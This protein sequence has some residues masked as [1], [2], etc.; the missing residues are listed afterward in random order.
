MPKRYDW[1][2]IADGMGIEK[3]AA[4]PG[5]GKFDW[6]AI[7]DTMGVPRE[8]PQP[9]SLQGPVPLSEVPQPYGPQAPTV[10]GPPTQPPGSAD[11]TGAWESFM[12]GEGLAPGAPPG[13][14][15][16]KYQQEG[17]IIPGVLGAGENL[18]K[19]LNIPLGIASAGANLAAGA[20]RLLV[21]P[22]AELAGN[23]EHAAE[24]HQ[25]GM[26]QLETP[27]AM[28]PDIAIETVKTAAQAA[29]PV[30]GPAVSGL[31]PKYGPQIWASAR[32]HGWDFQEFQERMHEDPLG[33]ALFLMPVLHGVLQIPKAVGGKAPLEPSKAAPRDMASVRWSEL[34][35]KAKSLE[36]KAVRISEDFLRANDLPTDLGYGLA[37]G[38]GRPLGKDVP[39][40]R[41]THRGRALD[42]P[43][44]AL[45]ETTFGA[46]TLD[47][48]TRK[49]P[50]KPKQESTGRR[51]VD[52]AL[53]ELDRVY[54]E[55]RA[56]FGAE[57]K[58]M[59][60]SLDHLMQ[61]EVDLGAKLERA[62]EKLEAAQTSR[63]RVAAK[64]NR[65]KLSEQGFK[66]EEMEALSDSQIYVLA[67]ME[68]GKHRDAFLQ[69]LRDQYKIGLEDPLAGKVA[70]KPPVETPKPQDAEPPA[71]EV[72]PPAERPTGDFAP[73][74]PQEGQARVLRRQLQ[75]IERQTQKVL[76]DARVPPP[77]RAEKLAA[78]NKKRAK[79][80]AALERADP[81]VPPPSAA[82]PKP[83]VAEPRRTVYRGEGA[84]P[85]QVYGPEAVA[86]GRAVPLF[87][88]GVYYARTRKEAGQYG[89]VSA[90]PE[91][92]LR[93]PM[94]LDSD[95]KWFKLLRDADAPHLNN[96]AEAFYKN[97][98]GVAPDTLK[99]QKYLKGRGHDGLV[100]R[101]SEGDATK[102][103][104]DMAGHDQVVVFGEAPPA[105]P[106]PIEVKPKQP[107]RGT[108][109]P[110]PGEVSPEVIRNY[111][112]QNGGINWEGGPEALGITGGKSRKG[113]GLYSKDPKK[114]L[115]HWAEDLGQ[116]GG[117]FPSIE[118]AREWLVE[119]LADTT[120]GKPGD[121][122]AADRA[123]QKAHTERGVVRGQAQAERMGVGNPEAAIREAQGRGRNVKTLKTDELTPGDVIYIPS[124]NDVFRVKRNPDPGFTREGPEGDFVLQDG[125]K[126]KPLIGDVVD[127]VNLGR[128]NVRPAIPKPA[129]KPTE[130]ALPGMEEAP[131]QIADANRKVAAERKGRE[132]AARTGQGTL[133]DEEANARAKEAGR[134][135]RQE[136]AGKKEFEEKQTTFESPEG[137]GTTVG[138]PAE[139]T[140]TYE[141]AEAPKATPLEA[142][143]GGAQPAPERGKTPDQVI[144]QTQIVA[145]FRR[146]ALAPI[147]PGV[148]KRALG[149]FDWMRR[150][151]RLKDPAD[152]GVA[153][154]E[155]GHA[156]RAVLFDELP[157]TVPFRVKG[158][159]AAN[160]ELADLGKALYKSKKPAGGY[161]NE[162]LAEFTR[163]WATDRTAAKA[164]APEFAKVFEKRLKGSDPGMDLAETFDTVHRLKDLY[165]AQ[166]AVAKVLS[167]IVTA[168]GYY[169]PI[170]LNRLYAGLLD[171]DHYLYVAT[172]AANGGVFPGHGIGVP[173]TEGVSYRGWQGMAELQIEPGGGIPDL[174]PNNFLG[175]LRRHR[176][177][178]DEALASSA[179][180]HPAL[181]RGMR[182]QERVVAA[183]I[184]RFVKE[185]YVE[186]R[187]GY[188]YVTK[189]GRSVLT[190]PG[191]TK[192]YD[193]LHDI[194]KDLAD[195]PLETARGVATAS[196]SVR[197]QLRQRLPKK[198]FDL[199]RTRN[200]DRYTVFH[201]SLR[202]I[203]AAE[204]GH[205]PEVVAAAKRGDAKA[206]AYIEK[207]PG[208]DP[209]IKYSEALA[210]V[211]ELDSPRFRRGVER[212]VEFRNHQLDMTVHAGMRT[213]E[214]A[215]AIKEAWP[216]Y[217]PFHR[218]Y[219]DWGGAPAAKGRA[220]GFPTKDPIQRMKGSPLPIMDPI[221]ALVS[222]T[223]VITQAVKANGVKRALVEYM[224][225]HPGSG[226]AVEPTKLKSKAINVKIREAVQG[227]QDWLEQEAGLSR[228]EIEQM[229]LEGNFRIFRPQDHVPKGSNI[230]TYFD[231]G[232][233][234]YVELDPELYR[235]VEGMDHE[236]AAAMIRLLGA[237]ARWVRAGAT[238]TPDF[239]ARNIMRDFISAVTQSELGGANP[240]SGYRVKWTAKGARSRYLRDDHWFR[241]KASGASNA[242][243]IGMDKQYLK[244]SL[245]DMQRSMTKTGKAGNVVLHPIE[246]MQRLSEFMEETTRVG[247]FRRVTEELGM[248]QDSILKAM[249][250]SRDASIDFG[251]RG[252]W[253]EAPSM[254]VDFLNA[255]LQGVDKFGR[256]HVKAAK[257]VGASVKG[258]REGKVVMPTD[259]VRLATRLGTY[260]IL[261]SI[262]SYLSWHATDRYDEYDD[263]PAWK[264]DL[265][266]NFPLPGR[267]NY[268]SLPKAFEIGVLYGSGTERML[269]WIYRGDRERFREYAP[270]LFQSF[271]PNIFPAILRPMTEIAADWGLY[272]ER[273]I[274][275]RAERDIDPAYQY[276]P[277]TS[278]TAK[279][280]AGVIRSVPGAGRLMS[281]SRYKSSEISPRMVDHYIWS[282]TAGLGAYYAVPALDRVIGLLKH[283]ETGR[284]LGIG[285][286]SSRVQSFRDIPLVRS[287]VSKPEQIGQ[288]AI[289][290]YFDQLDDATRAHNTY[291]HLVKKN[292]DLAGEYLE[293]G[294]KWKNITAYE[295]LA[296]A[297]RGVSVLLKARADAG[298]E[299]NRELQRKLQEEVL[300]VVKQAMT[301]AEAALEDPTQAEAVR[302][303]ADLHAL[304]VGRDRDRAMLATTIEQMIEQGRNSD[305][306]A[307]TRTMTDEDRKWARAYA[308]R[309]RKRLKQSAVERKIDKSPKTLLRKLA[310]P[311]GR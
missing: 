82:G 240:F 12:A 300:H 40:V 93:N 183:K 310:V 108:P 165:E 37:E 299:G 17:G 85:E 233:I 305:F 194:V 250:K 226:W 64:I 184:E 65:K 147:R 217:I 160:A 224:E 248:D 129:A 257:S 84:S 28:G 208:L 272:F 115:D 7:A 152:V 151:I 39:T 308:E 55:G 230:T 231:N 4:E 243:V 189:E 144:R 53:E 110:T 159:A 62:K 179:P 214:Q 238:L 16:Q 131:G 241:W 291:R 15:S 81:S 9:L 66:P 34:T 301:R 61:Q 274:T 96:M 284:R 140:G 176:L 57:E 72:A 286:K 242:T 25:A 180:V 69:E 292:P 90:H 73:T 304:R 44:D 279:L 54:D 252:Y 98:K 302:L 155:A 125:R 58:G 303:D 298:R 289:D 227:M 49:R 281:L 215:N 229:D 56:K 77:I 202:A 297:Q 18:Y 185:G 220:A 262:V 167:R 190:E 311:G 86:E 150:I 249:T 307:L 287:F 1:Q 153:S 222:D 92:Q 293:D 70:A 135:K 32:E 260:V 95:A 137:G 130:R 21:A 171:R 290:R 112:A 157:E 29:E 278:E 265:F 173:I 42:I 142:A 105:A 203:E 309:Y 26:R 169:R 210:A 99:L 258:L 145:E 206:I 188:Y 50:E 209:G 2:A 143:K 236:G 177:F 245:R 148:K 237:P 109:Y 197:E 22:G 132:D 36:G 59:E 48:R 282:S 14:W 261:P 91:P 268:F 251:R 3:P 24:M 33:T 124:E 256:V 306:Y 266:L 270:N 200:L 228:S 146:T 193:S 192:L 68:P 158:N 172:K 196:G 63:S 120:P 269:D 213:Q 259:A 218:I 276:G 47:R 119:N 27:A 107:R 41:V 97:P 45:A 255:G 247:V 100:V 102:R 294:E 186:K 138:Y 254:V 296:A 161:R 10:G 166:P 8:T 273:P 163:L 114:G 239:A 288:A 80:E 211:K 52:V 60:G 244:K 11:V 106:K 199:D 168:Q 204:K 285:S 104:R 223:Y 136:E 126:I 67:D 111:I 234:K 123:R 187:G 31:I 235:T 216:S 156:A 232:K 225:E 212:V 221:E 118:A 162:G 71:G 89:K 113:A 164:K 154:H 283:T 246:A 121:F 182:P 139:G 280:G 116:G 149:T 122:A 127:G 30:L 13:Y 51:E 207:N 46:E 23:R 94:V 205:K 117:P 43:P 134:Q 191:F 141:P 38:P 198:W 74:T 103:L 181:K 264:R 35:D 267:G 275:P 88:P 219:D 20:G 253:M 133:L 263:L 128:L 201:S 178:S 195:E 277:Y 83:I 75:A 295:H 19:G 5:R 78:L 174:R 76:D 271:M 6:Q 101:L 79:V 87:G 170:S 175:L